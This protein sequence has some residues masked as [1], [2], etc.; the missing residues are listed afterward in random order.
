MTSPENF[1][2]ATLIKIEGDVAIIKIAHDQEIKWQKD[3]LPDNLKEGDSFYLSAQKEIIAENKDD[4]QTA[5]HLLEEIL[6]GK[7]EKKE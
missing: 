2:K 3:K 4:Q 6:N 1:Q 5:I 7:S